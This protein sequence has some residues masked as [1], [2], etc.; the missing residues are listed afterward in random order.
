M[1][2]NVS[3]EVGQDD[4]MIYLS[5]DNYKEFVNL[6][7]VA[8]SY[9]H[10]GEIYGMNYVYG[11]MKIELC[12]EVCPPLKYCLFGIW[13]IEETPSGWKGVSLGAGNFLVLADPIYYQLRR[14]I[15]NMAPHILYG[16]WIDM[17]MNCIKL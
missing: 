2:E 17:V 13:D 6:D 15:W 11:D 9:A 8:F 12:D 7:V 1:E 4:K 3:N 16:R 5:K 10:G 14:Q